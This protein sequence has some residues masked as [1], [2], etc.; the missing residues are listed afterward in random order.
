MIA[1]ETTRYALRQALID[2]Q[3]SQRAWAKRKGLP[4]GTSNDCLLR[5]PMS[6]RRENTL[7]SA[8]GLP[9]TYTRSVNIHPETEGV[10]KRPGYGKKRGYV[11]FK[12]RV[13]PQEAEAIRAYLAVEG[14]GSFSEWWH[15]SEQVD[16]M[17]S[18]PDTEYPVEPNLRG[19]AGR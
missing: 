18:T 16:Q 14:Y 6:R 15:R 3:S 5:K 12:I 19:Q 7:R 9:E 13:T 2:S 1:D 11:E 17:V 4:H 10:V 8:L